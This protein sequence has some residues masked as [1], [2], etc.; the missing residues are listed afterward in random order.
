MSGPWNTPPW[1]HVAVYG[2]GISGQSA[3][4]LLLARGAAVTAVDDRPREVLNLGALG[5]GEAHPQL[6]LRCGG[7]AA[8]SPLPEGLDGLV[9]SPGVPPDR[10]WIAAAR[11]AG[12]P[13]ISEVELAF[14]LLQGPVVGITGTNGKSTTTEMTGAILRAA[15]QSV[16]VCGNIG[17]AISGRVDGPAGRTFV[18]EMSS[19]QLEAVDTFRPRAAALLNLTPDHL[20]R[21]PSFEAYGAAKAILFRRQEATDVAVFNADDPRVV[22]LAA[23]PGT[24]QG[25]RRWFS[26]TGVVDD[27][28]YLHGEEVL[29]VEPRRPPTLLFPREAVAVPGAHNLENAMAAALLARARGVEPAV[30]TRALRGFRGLPHRMERVA[31]VAGVLFYDDSKG[32]NTAATA[33]SLE[34]LPD[35]GVHLILGGRAKG[36]DPRELAPLLRS[37]ARHL[38][39]IGEAAEPFAAA[40][41]GVAPL[42]VVQ[43]LERA[44]E[45]A[46][47]QARGGEVV[48][49]SPACASFDQFSSYRQRGERFQQL[50]A[51][52][53]DL[54]PQG[55]G[56]GQEARL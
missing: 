30:V 10:P 20:D 42:T 23:A 35:G 52:L 33:K 3:V 9:L 27:G 17:E 53:V 43:T 14:P 32:T 44:V 39:L 15:G 6:T 36:D 56:H 5:E 2:L 1:R 34:D 21:Y 13:V 31:E 48:L 46:A 47:A 49:L 45:R 25:R 29:E 50:V 54:S 55:G 8:G 40:L 19:F 51:Q 7:A 37:K 22:A 28:C 38:Y 24:G 12:L 26:R 11:A 18:V 41:E 16:E 4:R